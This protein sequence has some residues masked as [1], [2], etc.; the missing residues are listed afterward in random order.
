MRDVVVVGAGPAGITASIY[1]VR[2][3]LDVLLVEPFQPGGA[4]NLTWKIEN[5]PGFPGGIEGA[6]LARRF[7]GHLREYGIEPYPDSVEKI[8]AGKPHRIL[9][10]SGEKVEARAV[11]IATGATPKKLGVPGEKEFTGR[12]VSYCAVCDGPFFKNRIV[13]VVGGGDSACDEAAYLA[14]IAEKVYLI[15]RRD[16]L[17]ASQ[18]IA[19]RVLNNS[20]IEILWNTV[21]KEIKGENTVK[22]VVLQNVKTGQLFE[23]AVNGVFIY[24]GEVANSGFIDVE[25]DENGFIKTDENMATSVE[26]VF[27][28]GDVRAK[29]LRQ[30]VTA[31]SEG[32]LAA[33]AAYRWIAE[34]WATR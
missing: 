17:R 19:S 30:I 29:S 24:I 9:L 21:V 32:A 28:A 13:A 5:Y 11:I 18:A 23:L 25:K 22:A 33:T 20:K 14:T 2:Y 34:K 27:A 4:I 31:A 8:I 12:G 16:S 1:C 26:G 7:A 6:Q 3:G 15:H 10:S